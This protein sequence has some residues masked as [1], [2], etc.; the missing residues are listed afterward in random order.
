MVTGW[1]ALGKWGSLGKEYLKDFNSIFRQLG[2]NKVVSFC[3]AFYNYIK[4][5]VVEKVSIGVTRYVANLIIDKLQLV[6]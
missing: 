5:T 6:F 2:H 3:L 1:A 4:S